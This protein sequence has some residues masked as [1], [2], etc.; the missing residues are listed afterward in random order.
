[1]GSSTVAMQRKPKRERPVRTVRNK[2][3]AIKMYV[4]KRDSA[5]R[6]TSVML[7]GNSDVLLIDTQFARSEAYRLAGEIL[8]TGRNLTAVYISHAHPDHYFGND[9]LGGAF[10]DAKF[11]ALPETVREIRET[12][13]KKVDT[14]A[15]AL[16]TNAPKR[17]MIPEALAERGLE[18]EG[19][20]LEILGPLQG[21]SPGNT[22]VWIPSL[23]TLVAS[24]TVFADTHVWTAGT[25]ADERQDWLKTLDRL[26]ALRPRVVIPGH[27]TVDTILDR[28]AIEFTRTYLR[29]FDRELPRAKSVAALVN[30]M[31]LR[32][33]G[34]ALP[35]A[36]ELGAK[37][38]LDA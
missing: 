12:Y 21:D 34:A 1:M 29:T 16:G 4:A 20:R 37:A 32:F 28:T 25:N 3:L 2:D 38:N 17:V 27:C 11:V 18:F 33:P 5:M 8:E 24:D 31:K 22:A 9:V 19:Q 7:V 35:L 14:W 30:A 26:E 23:R 13:Q 10:P 36:I 15:A 6:V